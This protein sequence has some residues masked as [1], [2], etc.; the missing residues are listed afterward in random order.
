VLCESPK[1]EED[2]LLMAKTWKR[3]VASEAAG[4]KAR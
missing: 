2:A 1:M 3:V 4:K